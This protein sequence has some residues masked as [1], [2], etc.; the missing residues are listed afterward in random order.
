ME[1]AAKFLPGGKTCWD[2]AVAALVFVPMRGSGL[3]L[4]GGGWMTMFVFSEVCEIEL[5]M[6]VLG[7][8]VVL[9]S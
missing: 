3:I 4:D 2:M 8:F 1:W 5:S 9:K 6:V 7:L